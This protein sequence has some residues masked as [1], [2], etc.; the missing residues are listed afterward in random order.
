MK[1]FYSKYTGKYSWLIKEEGWVRSLQGVRETQ[2]ALGNGL[3]GSRG[4]LEEL[5]YDAKPGTFVA[6]LYD[7]VAS[8]VDE[9]VN[10]PNPFNFKLTADGEKVG[11]VT[12]DTV[13][14]RRTLNLKHGL[15]CRHTVLQDTKARKYDYQSMRFLSMH[16]KRVGVMQVVFTPL[17]SD[18]VI[19]IETGIDTSVYNAGT[20]TEGRKKHFR[21]RE[22]GQFKKEGFLI[23]ES[24]GRQHK[25]IFRSG[26]YYVTNGRKTYAKDNIFEL[27][28]KKNQTVTFTKTFHIYAASTNSDL[29]E[30]KT[31][32]RKGFRGAFQS[33]FQSL[34]KKH[35]NAWEKLWDTAEVTIWGDPEIE[36]NFR[37]NIYHLLI[38][39]PQDQGLS[40]IGAKALTGEG[41][42]GHIFWDTEIFMFPFYLYTLPNAARNML[43]YRYKR[44]DSAR[45]LAKKSGYKGAM[46]P[47]ESA[48]SGEEETPAYARDL[49]G[50]VI[51]IHTGELEHHI[52]AD[53]AY[54]FYHYYNAT[55]DEKFMKECGY[56][57]FFESARFWASRVE[58]N[59]KRKKYEIKHVIGPDEFHKDVDN[60]AFTNMAAKWNLLT[61]EKM[62]YKLKRSDA[63]TYKRLSKASLGVSAAEAR[64]WKKIAARMY[65]N[66][67]R[68]QIIEQF[69]GYF[70]KKYI[71]LNGW[72]ENS[73]PTPP[74]GLT[75][76]SYE[77][78][79]LVKQAD[80]LM[81]MY[82]FMDVFNS[83]SKKNNYEYYVNRTL[84]KSSLSLPIYALMAIEVGDRGRAV[85]YFNSALHM[86]ISNIN[87]NT[88]HGIHAAAIGA[89]WQVLI[90]GFCGVRIEKELLLVRPRL[91]KT[92]RKVLFNIHWRGRLLRF[93][94][95]ND[96]VKVQ[97]V[98][99]IKRK[100]KIKVFGA[101][102]DLSANKSYIFS[103][104]KAARSGSKDYYL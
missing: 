35:I 56:E 25:V 3:L 11:V 38:C 71:R 37:F 89:T 30:I 7:D 47:W 72:D 53:V 70:K 73:V 49:D 32:S 76:R 74:K 27:K 61:A 13:S 45:E 79:Q 88:D 67:N 91:M 97:V 87:S 31:I 59:K 12:M 22:L 60:N 50:K 46:F 4:I 9:L 81:L 6:G 94:I 55:R 103:R 77:K 62:F 90:N 75:P 26:L 39:A 104:T 66:I 95:D 16:D 63:A 69:D 24:F 19:N 15:L 80:V 1:D 34:L 65:I 8:Q 40:S 102:R 84:H 57:V 99:K 33:S 54:A 43:L 93:E 42:R 64:Q 48:S 51:R 92:W 96:R 100:F 58:Y 41:Y 36:K 85:R 68:Q 98:S 10:W 23:T 14:H 21:V 82:L 101:F 28:L 44:L 20:V 17:D 5:P 83:K 2:L 29:K 78:T 18:V 52:T 86:D